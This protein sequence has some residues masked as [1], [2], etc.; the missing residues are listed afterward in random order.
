MTT[1]IKKD[2]EPLEQIKKMNY[3]E[4]YA[5]KCYP[6]GAVFDTKARNVSKFEWEKI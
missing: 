5:E 4:K 6:I 1:A 3:Y 2:R